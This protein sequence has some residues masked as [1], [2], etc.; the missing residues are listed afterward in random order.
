MPM[1][2]F[3]KILSNFEDI[4]GYEG[5]S[6]CRSDLIEMLEGFRPPEGS[7]IQSDLSGRDSI[8]IT[9]G[10][11]IQLANQPHL[12]TL[13]QFLAAKVKD[14]ISAVHLLPFFPYS[15]DDGF[16][17]I[18][19]H[20]VDPE[21]G[22]WEDIDSLSED[23]DLMFD[24]VINHISVQSEWF[25]AF[26]AG[27]AKYTDYF[28]TVE[29][30]ADIRNVFRPRA[31]PLLTAFKTKTG[32]I[33]VWTTFSEDQVDLNYHNP[34]VTV[35]ILKILLSF[36]EHG[37]KF[38]RL[39][40]I[41]YIWKEPGS[42]CIHLKKAHQIVQLFRSVFD[43]VAPFV[44]IITETNVPHE[45]NISY[46]GDGDN[47]AQLVYNFSLPPL[48]LH[49]FHTE[50]AET[51]TRWAKNLKTPS[52]ET[53]F[54][55]FLAS[56]DGIGVTPAKGLI[57][58]LEIQQMCDRVEALGGFVSYK[59]NAEGS[60]SPYELNI[61]F[62]DALGDPDCRNESNKQMADRFL[63]SQSILLALKGVPG[64]YY[65]S[66][67]GSQSWKEGVDITGRNRTINRE[68]LDLAVLL[69]ELETPNTL[70]HKVFNGY[71]EMLRARGFSAEGAF[72][73][74]SWQFIL[75]L[76]DRLMTIFRRSP[77][78]QTAVLCL[79]NVTQ[80]SLELDLTHHLLPLLPLAED[81]I[82][83]EI[84]SMN[85]NLRGASDRLQVKMGPYGVLWLIAERG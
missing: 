20:L 47:E 18:D 15:S 44:K 45:E 34:Q 46:F 38:I 42:S 29:D 39:D 3:E 59:D 69:R 14:A 49:A 6:A 2:N 11:A 70:R 24:A 16:S 28:I 5:V 4:Y 33:R 65:H 51:L 72:S 22:T 81:Q 10:D 40:A 35:D 43:C 73:P 41:A 64:I 52:A 48:V 56:H 68:K 19:Y 80:D 25:Q 82:W 50:S 36:V 27:K 60:R 85:C 13:K 7:K 83:H 32:I 77:D 12:Q 67:L 76:D 84:L 53:H 75:D 54:F 63:A 62:L 1:S 71:L 26:L 57:S 9:Y 30:E 31:L 21:L 78:Q 37:A 58:T 61:N 74:R 55:N 17:V 66:L 8:L 23:Y 79:T